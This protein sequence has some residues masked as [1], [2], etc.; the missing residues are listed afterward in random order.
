MKNKHVLHFKDEKEKYQKIILCLFVILCFYGCYKNGLSYYFIGK[1]SL[2]ESLKPLLFPIIGI[3]ETSIFTISFK[4]KITLEKIS[5]GI[6][7]GLLVPPM[8][9]LIIF[10][11]YTAIFLILYFF[12]SKK[13]PS[14]SF[15]V[16]YKV[17]LMG[18]TAMNSLGLENIIEKNNSYL[19]GIVDVFFGKGIGNIGT[20]NIFL[21]LI[22]YFI[23]SSYFYYKKELPIYAL[24]SYAICSL[25]YSFIKPDVFIL[26]DMLNS[27][28]CFAITFLLPINEKSPGT[29]KEKIIYG[30]LVGVGSF[31][32]IHLFSIFD[33]VFIVLL[34]VNIGWNLTLCYRMR[35]KK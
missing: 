18:I 16:L 21:I 14:I 19:Y 30:C 13:I 12:T 10:S 2:E 34:L 23:L 1:M 8:F 31:L 5:L 9:S 4:Q 26:K 35:Q 27:S 20:T 3:L 22:G 33:G 25:I 7:F 24:A 32:L 6:L 11:I 17:I 28:F 29:K 15:L